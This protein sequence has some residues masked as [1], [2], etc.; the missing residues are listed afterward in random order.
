[1][2]W[3]EPGTIPTARG[4]DHDGG[5]PTTVRAPPHRT[6][7]RGHLIEA[8]GEEVRELDERNR[9]ATGQRTS[10][11]D[12]NDQALRQGGVAHPSRELPGQPARQTEDVTLGILDVLAEQR[13]PRILGQAG[14]EHRTHGGQQ[15]HGFRS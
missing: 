15:R 9:P 10:D 3:A 5:F 4:Q 13:H 2:E 8:K 12:A 14:P 1:M 6:Q 7:L 11:A